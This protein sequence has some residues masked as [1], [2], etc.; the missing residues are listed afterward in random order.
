MKTYSEIEQ[1]LR[2]SPDFVPPFNSE[3]IDFETVLWICWNHL[4]E[5]ERRIIFLYYEIGN[6]TELA[7]ILGVSQATTWYHVKK[8]SSKIRK[9]Y[10]ELL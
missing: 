1:S 6:Y 8:I 5:I 2:I 9:I 3:E 7:K 10:D 4:T